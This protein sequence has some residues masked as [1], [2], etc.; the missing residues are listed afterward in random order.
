M[1]RFLS[2]LV[3][4][5]VLFAGATPS[6]TAC[7]NDRESQAHEKEFKSDYLRQPAGSV[8]TG[9]AEARPLDNI[10]VVGISAL[11]VALLLAAAVMGTLV[12]VHRR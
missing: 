10:K 5:V 7:I 9:P 4:T 3:L 12:A 8:P 11:G 1:F 6:A 2:L